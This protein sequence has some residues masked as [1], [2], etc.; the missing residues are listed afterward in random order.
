VQAID[1]SYRVST[2]YRDG[3]FKFSGFI[4]DYHS[5]TDSPCTDDTADGMRR[6]T[7]M[8]FAPE[9]TLKFD[10]N[11]SLELKPSFVL[12][13]TIRHRFIAPV[14][15]AANMNYDPASVPGSYEDGGAA[16]EMYSGKVIYKTTA[17]TNQKACRGVE[18]SY[19]KFFLGESLMIPLLKLLTRAFR[20][21]GQNQAYLPKMCL[22]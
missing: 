17:L 12:H 5:S 15:L 11:N 18:Y 9:Y 13:D 8:L 22:L 14:T 3:N 4:Q 6:D 2:N 1:P 19:S 16:S 7:V 21:A 20:E 10:E